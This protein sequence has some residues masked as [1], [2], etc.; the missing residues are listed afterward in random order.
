MILSPAAAAQAY[1]VCKG[2]NHKKKKKQK[3]KTK[4]DSH[5]SYMRGKITLKLLA[6]EEHS[7][8]TI[9]DVT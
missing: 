4:H 5:L 9:L 2:K 3:T 1:C 6:L 8:V 7:I